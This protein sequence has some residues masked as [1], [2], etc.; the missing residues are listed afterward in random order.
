MTKAYIAG[1]RKAA[2]AHGVDP[3][4]LFALIEKSADTEDHSVRNA[5]GE[6]IGSFGGSTAGG[7]GAGALAGAVLAKLRRK[8]F[9]DVLTSAIKGGKLG[10]GVGAAGPFL[11]SI[12]ALATRGRNKRSQRKHDTEGRF[13]EGSFVPGVGTYNLWKRLGRIVREASG[14]R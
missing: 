14:N 8:G 12:A 5:L 4:A 3:Q 1:F 13:L 6:I 2:E 11:G 7:T 9:A 10:L